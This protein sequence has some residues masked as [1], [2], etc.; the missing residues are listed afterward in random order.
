MALLSIRIYPLYAGFTSK[1][2]QGF[3]EQPAA[4]M[5]DST[6][7]ASCMLEAEDYTAD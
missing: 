5:L 3:L 1:Y 2:S 7:Y 4:E 6:H